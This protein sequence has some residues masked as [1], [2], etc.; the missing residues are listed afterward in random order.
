MKKNV[1]TLLEAETMADEAEL[2]A[3]P[4]THVVKQ[5][6]V[7]VKTVRVIDFKALER[8]LSGSVPKKD[9]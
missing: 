6:T 4:F 2:I 5:T 7:N 9:S 3:K 8:K 1:N